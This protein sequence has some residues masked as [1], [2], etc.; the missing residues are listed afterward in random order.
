VVVRRRGRR[1]AVAVGGRGMVTQ[2]V[3]GGQRR[4][5]LP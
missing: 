2:E 5:G 4:R 1:A 3:I